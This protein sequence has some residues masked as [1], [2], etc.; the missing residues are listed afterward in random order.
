MKIRFWILL[1]IYF[2]S[3]TVLPAS[4]SGGAAS[5][6]GAVLGSVVSHTGVG[7]NPFAAIPADGRGA[8]APALQQKKYRWVKV[9][10]DY[11]DTQTGYC[12]MVEEIGRRGF[13][14][15]VGLWA[16]GVCARTWMGDVFMNTEHPYHAPVIAT[17]LGVGAAGFGIAHCVCGKKRFRVWVKREEFDGIVA[18]VH[19]AEKKE[20]ERLKGHV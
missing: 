14:C 6:G 4:E 16:A 3:A 17:S 9:E 15:F 5:G 18:S 19:E 8:Q 13:G 11:M 1:S 12:H 7:E 10:G 20:A 2:Y